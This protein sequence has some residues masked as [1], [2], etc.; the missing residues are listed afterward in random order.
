L[1]LHASWRSF[2]AAWFA[3]LSKKCLARSELA[4]FAAADR[5]IND[6]IATYNREHAHPFTWKQGVRFYHR[7]KDKLAANMPA[8]A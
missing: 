3:L 2:I 8:A 5:T 4:D 1:P 7:L 6:F